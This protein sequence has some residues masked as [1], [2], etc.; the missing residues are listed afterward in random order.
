MLLDYNTHQLITDQLITNHYNTTMKFI[1]SI[2]LT[3]FSLSL[4]AQ[5]GVQYTQ[6]MFNKLG[7]NPAYAGSHEVPCISAIHRS[8]WVGFD[9]A[10]TSQAFN[11]HTPLFAKRVGMGLSVQHDKIGPTNSY[12]I[13]LSYAYRMQIEEST[14]SFGL[15]GTMRSYEV[16]FSETESVVAGD[17]AVMNGSARKM[18]PNFGVGIYYLGHNLFAGL[19]MPYILQG[20]I[21]LYE[22]SLAANQDFSV[23]ERHLYFMAGYKVNLNEKVKFKPAMMFKSVR[24]APADLDLHGSFVFNDRLGVGATYRLGGI[25]NSFGESVD[26]LMYLQFEGGFRLGAAYD[27]TLSQLR[28]YQSGSFEILLEKCLIRKNSRLTNPRFFL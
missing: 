15:Q 6:F 2:L 11:F 1:Y 24:H 22:T 4:Y 12:W 13:N 27:L 5:Q 23:E 28:D 18:L 14:L 9:G 3:L 20:D 21:S 16:D 10:P 26:F 17:P 7:F 8:Q 19:S 25:R